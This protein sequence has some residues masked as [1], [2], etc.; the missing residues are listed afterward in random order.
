MAISEKDL[1]RLW[2]LSGGRCAYPACNCDCLPFLGETDPT[3]IGEMAHVIAKKPSGPRGD[4]TGGDDTYENLV[5][6]CPTHHTL[7]DKAPDGKYT[8]EMLHHWK[9]KHEESVSR[10]LAAPVF[11]D[12]DTDSSISLSQH[13]RQRIAHQVTHEDLGEVAPAIHGTGRLG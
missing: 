7:V 5:L 13:H 3:V 9:A 12:R 2:G 11:G 10:A 1:K 6:L 8:V 4:G